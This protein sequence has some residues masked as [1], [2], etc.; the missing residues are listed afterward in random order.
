MIAMENVAFVRFARTPARRCLIAKNGAR[1]QSR[2]ALIIA[3][4]EKVSALF[5]LVL[6]AL[7]FKLL[8]NKDS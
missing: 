2:S 7:N 5:V 1:F 3:S 8:R 6:V 4:R